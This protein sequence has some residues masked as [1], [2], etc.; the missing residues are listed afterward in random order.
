MELIQLM[1]ELIIT[2]LL[3]IQ[4]LSLTLV[5]KDAHQENIYPQK[6]LFLV[7]LVIPWIAQ[8]SK[9]QSALKMNIDQ[10]KV[11]LMT[12]VSSHASLVSISNVLYLS[13]QIVLKINIDQ[14]QDHSMRKVTEI[15]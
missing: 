11:E 10:K 14:K 13:F 3:I 4:V 9:F 1:E 7:L 15:V 6:L 8:T 5:I 12:K 2:T